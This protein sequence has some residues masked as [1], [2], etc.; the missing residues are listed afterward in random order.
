MVGVTQ[1]V[2]F[3]I[4]GLKNLVPVLHF[5]H[6]AL[7]LFLVDG[8]LGEEVL[9]CHSSVFVLCLD[10]NLL[11]VQFLLAS[12]VLDLHTDLEYLHHEVWAGS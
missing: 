6:V 1:L 9:D 10:A 7:H 3:L 2:A 4:D 8:G 12:R 5:L 11:G